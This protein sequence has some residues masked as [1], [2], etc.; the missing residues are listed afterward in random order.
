MQLR[1]NWNYPTPI[2]FGAGRVTELPSLCAELNIKNPLI[3]TDP[4]LAK[5]PVIATVEHIF[6]DAGMTA[7]VWCDL[8]PNPV[9][10][11]VDAGVV[12]FKAGGHD[13][14]VAVGGGSALDVGKAV[15]LMVGQDRPLWDF[16]DIGDN[17]LRVKVAA[18]APVI[19]VPT[20]SGTGSEVGRAS[21]IIEETEH[22]KVIIFH[23]AMLPPRVLADPELTAGLPPHLTAAT[24]VDALVH[25][26]EAY[27]S[28]FY[29]PLAAGVG[30]EGMKMVKDWLPTAYADGGNIEARS[31][32]L[33]ASIAGATA[34]QKGLGGVHALAHPIGAV[35]NTH[36]GLTNA[37]LLPYVLVRNKS[38]I[39]RQLT[40]A[41]RYLDLP[42]PSFDCFLKWVLDLRAQLKIP[43]TLAEIGVN[44]ERAD[45]I[46]AMAKLDASDG[47]NPIELSAA[48]YAQIV[49][50]A[51]A[52]TL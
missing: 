47:G 20:T 6:K 27:C 10:R 49:R 23:A 1:G 39:E 28:P 22:R 19:A 40:D 16:E 24:G 35:Y 3:I 25:N 8:S 33:I 43:H 9:G 45:E 30:L 7:A 31:H 34:F 48:D 13:G 11:D 44:A 50:N 4:G 12:A 21:V 17:Y 42:N 5:L 14:I 52:G 38:G 46:G 18:M 15:G 51:V 36:H 2:R 41:A 29:H 26:L 32:M 37:V